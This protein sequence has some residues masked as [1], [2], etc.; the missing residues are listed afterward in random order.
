M[1]TQ[2]TGREP[3]LSLQTNARGEQRLSLRKLASMLNILPPDAVSLPALDEM[4]RNEEFY[5]R[6]N[7]AQM[8]GR[9]GDREARLIMQ[10]ALNSGETPTRASVARHLYGFSWFSAEPLL[11]QALKDH[12]TRVR[13]AAIY[14]LCDL[15]ELNAYQLMTEILKAEG[16][17]VK[18]AAAWGLRNSQDSAAVPVLEAVLS[19]EDPEVRIKGLEALGQNDTPEAMPV[20]RQ[21]M[22]DPDPDVKYAATLSLLELAGEGWLQELSGIIGRTTGVTR[23]QILRGFFHATN[24]LKIDVAK[25]QSA[26]LL[27]DALETALLDDMDDVR[28]AVVWPLAWMRHD[29]TPGVLKR[30]YLVEQSETVKAHMVRVASSLMSDA[31]DEILQDALKHSGRVRQVADQIMQDRGGRPPIKYETSAMHASAGV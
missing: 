15:R 27:I 22:N 13:E 14:A 2:I 30:A 7:A 21:A 25:T 26:D 1:T 19:A 29:R 17:D 11:R 8:L 9:R 10:N 28:M 24:Y 31:A 3:R 20:V 6:Y 5:V 12:D 18:M 16:D 23:Q 4:L